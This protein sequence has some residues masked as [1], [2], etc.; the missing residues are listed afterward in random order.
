MQLHYSAVLALLGVLGSSGDLNSDIPPRV[1]GLVAQ[2][3]SARRPNVQVRDALEVLSATQNRSRASS[4][5]ATELQKRLSEC[6][7]PIRTMADRAFATG[8]FVESAVYFRMALVLDPDSREARRGLEAAALG[9][10]LAGGGHQPLRITDPWR[11]LKW[12]RW[13]LAQP[14]EPQACIDPENE[15]TL[16]LNLTL[17]FVMMRRTAARA[18]LCSGDR[19]QFC[20]ENYRGN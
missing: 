7:T 15:K 11:E 10:L 14:I 20:G 18:L 9:R 2:T 4:N 12:A 8:K 3:S 16:N 1:R 6:S 19:E 13:G 17:E 5:L